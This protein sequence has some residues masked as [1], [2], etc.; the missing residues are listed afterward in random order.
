M[1]STWTE[2]E[3]RIREGVDKMDTSERD[4]LLAELKKTGRVTV[5]SSIN[6]IASLPFELSLPIP[7]AR[8][9]IDVGGRNLKTK[10]SL[11]LSQPTNADAHIS[12]AALLLSQ[13]P[14][15]QDHAREARSELETALRLLPQDSN[16]AD[17]RAQELAMV[18]DFLG[19]AL[20]ALNQVPE[21]REHWQI[22]LDTDPVRPPFGFSGMAQDKLEKHP[23]P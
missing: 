16:S 6:L 22:A 3:I 13:E 1:V 9:S 5:H 17:Y 18:H 23:I 7:F 15:T 10:R 19:D 21:A 8:F 12:L 4:R 2:G 11:V 14:V 20:L